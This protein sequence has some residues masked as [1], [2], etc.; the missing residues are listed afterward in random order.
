MLE[1]VKLSDSRTFMV[2]L[3]FMFKPTYHLLHVRHIY[4]DGY[5]TRVISTHVK[6]DFIV[7]IKQ[8]PPLEAYVDISNI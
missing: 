8:I 6:F 5:L 3:S 4:D 7:H 2:M 1:D